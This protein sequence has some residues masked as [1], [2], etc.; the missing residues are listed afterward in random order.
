[1]QGEF[2]GIGAE[3]SSRKK[4]ITIIS[5]LENSPAKRAG[6]QPLDQ[7]LK[8]DDKSTENLNVDE[9]VSLI[10]GQKGTEVKLLIMREG[11]DKP[12]E[13]K[14][15]RDTIKI[16]VLKWQMKDNVAHIQL[17]QFTEN[18]TEEFNKIVPE[19]TKANPKGIILDLRGNPGGYLEAAVE[20]AGWFMPGG[21]LIV[22]EDFGDSKKIE[23][24]TSNGYQDLE[25]YPLVVLIDA[26]SASASEILAG[27]LRD[28]KGVKLVG[29]KSFGKGSVQQLDNLTG[30]SS[31]KITIAKWLTP[32]GKNI[33]HDGLEPDEKVELK[34]E[35]LDKNQDPQFN[36]ALEMLKN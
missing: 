15:I 23:H 5:P 28:N 12:K 29:T 14:I 19:I 35:D 7:I 8:I 24:R 10:R 11:F 13:F 22:T 6:L 4:I 25:K 27:A 20:L 31:L 30:G 17:F 2:G 33:M 32:G 1:M 3:V 9:A 36:K 16:P 21:K 34:Q 18:V 26:G